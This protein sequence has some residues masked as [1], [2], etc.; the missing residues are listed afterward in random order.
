MNK[1]HKYTAPRP[2]RAVETSFQDEETGGRATLDATPVVPESSLGSGA[3][4][5]DG[6]VW[7]DQYGNEMSRTGNLISDISLGG[8]AKLGI[9]YALRATIGRIGQY[10]EW[11][12]GQTDGDNSFRAQQRRRVYALGTA[13]LSSVAAVAVAVP[14][15]HSEWLSRPARNVLAGDQAKETQG[16]LV[17]SSDGET[18]LS[19]TE[20]SNYQRLAKEAVDG[21]TVRMD[22]GNNRAGMDVKIDSDSAQMTDGS[23]VT[24]LRVSTGLEGAKAVV[25]RTTNGKPLVSI[26]FTNPTAVSEAQI[27]SGLATSTT[28]SILSDGKITRIVLADLTENDRKYGPMTR[29]GFDLRLDDGNA[30][31][32][33]ADSGWARP[34]KSRVR[35]GLDESLDALQEE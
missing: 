5:W 7:R 12:D 8:I 35:E 20:W 29:L 30:T 10:S 6:A 17:D 23:D 31:V 28:R 9:R 33:P 3:P 18:I 19:P 27:D 21:A 25:T 11:L 14:A 24:T 26:E 16:L 4:A 15:T 34:S 32:N 22:N 2:R 13:V 1:S